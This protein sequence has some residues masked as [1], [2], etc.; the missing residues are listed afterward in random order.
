[1]LVDLYRGVRIVLK[2]ILWDLWVAIFNFLFRKQNEKIKD[3]YLKRVARKRR[4]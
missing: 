2:F 4:L 1:M 3:T